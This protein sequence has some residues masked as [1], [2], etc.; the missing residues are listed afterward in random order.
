MHAYE[1]HHIPRQSG[2]D[3]ESSQSQI[4]LIVACSMFSILKYLQI[5]DS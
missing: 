1:Q 3:T 5:F 2:I 4:Y